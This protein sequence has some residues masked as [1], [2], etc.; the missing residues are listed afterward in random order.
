MRFHRICV[1]ILCLLAV[2]PAHALAQE[3]IRILSN[4]GSRTARLADNDA[5]RAFARMLPLILEMYNQNGQELFGYLPSSLPEVPRQRDFHPGTLGVWRTT[6]FSIY[7]VNGIEPDP[8]FIPV[9]QIIGNADVFFHPG[10]LVIRIER[11]D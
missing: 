10:M 5:G 8:G 6:G 2:M 7:Y 4:W 1:I 11:I 9:G 3:Q